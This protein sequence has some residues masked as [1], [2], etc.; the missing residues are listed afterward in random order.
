MSPWQNIPILYIDKILWYR[1]TCFI[2]MSVCLLIRTV[3]LQVSSRLLRLTIQYLLPVITSWP[4]RRK[5]RERKKER[6]KKRTARWILSRKSWR[7]LVILFA[8]A[9]IQLLYRRWDKSCHRRQVSGDQPR[10]FVVYTV[11]IYCKTIMTL[12]IEILKSFGE[13]KL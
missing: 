12:Y 6:K 5:K 4:R 11:I 7:H 2:Y 1:L 3:L 13:S 8:C 10:K 9:R